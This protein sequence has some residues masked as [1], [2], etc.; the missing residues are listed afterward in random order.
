MA[1]SGAP[2][3]RKVSGQ[4]R[5]GTRAG[6]PTG[7]RGTRRTALPRLGGNPH[8]PHASLISGQRATE[9]RGGD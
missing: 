5:A 6:N 8:G 2:V 1:V 7:S 9:K 3:G 4:V